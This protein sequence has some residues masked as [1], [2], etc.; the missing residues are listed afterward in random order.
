MAG[1]VVVVAV[2]EIPLVVLEARVYMVGMA[3]LV[4]DRLQTVEM[5]NSLLVEEVDL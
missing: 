1:A 3:V 2:T 5:E 4:G